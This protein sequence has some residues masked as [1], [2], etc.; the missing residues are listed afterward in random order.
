MVNKS[1][2]LMG[3]TGSGKSALALEIAKHIPCEIISVDSTSVYRGLDIGSAKP[4]LSERQICPHH[5]IDF[6]DPAEPFSVV[7]FCEQVEKLVP[8]IWA[9]NKVPLLVGGSM[10]YFNALFS[11][12][13][14]L[15]ASDLALRKRYEELGKAEGIG[16]LYRRL[17]LVDIARAEMLAPSDTQRIIRALCVY[18]QT[19][20]PFSEQINNNFCTSRLNLLGDTLNMAIFVADRADLHA[21]INARFDLML[22]NG[23]VDEVKGL[24]GRGDLSLSLPSIRSVGYRQTWDALLAQN[25]DLDD[26]RLKGQAATRQL[27]KRQMTWLRSLQIKLNCQSLVYESLTGSKQKQNKF[28]EETVLQKILTFLS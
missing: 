16:A 24:M 17:Q 10:M 27:A 21:R 28:F 6:C 23:L 9:R 1:L 20:K 14:D 5:L 13:D 22:A 2:C 26:L 15:P 18:D 7:H 4:S 12:L 19:G 3:P 8:A 25:F 11:P